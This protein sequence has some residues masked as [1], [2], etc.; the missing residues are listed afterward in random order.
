M[1]VISLCTL[2]HPAVVP[3]NL[4]CDS[5]GP[6]SIH[7]L[8]LVWEWVN[9][10]DRNT[11]RRPEISMFPTVGKFDMRSSVQNVEYLFHLFSLNSPHKK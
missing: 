7:H 2:T 4:F 10:N 5:G 1:V 6:S 8:P 11:S 9:A 3:F